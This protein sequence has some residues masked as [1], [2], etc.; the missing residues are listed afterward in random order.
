[1]SFLSDVFSGNF[2]NLG[3]DL[4]PSNI[5]SDTGSSFSNQPGWAQGLELGGAALLG[6]LALPELLPAAGALDLGGGAAASFGAASDAF[7]VAGGLGPGLAGT[8]FDTTGG[9][10]LAGLDASAI[11]SNAVL[12]ATSSLTAGTSDAFGGAG[13]AL[14]MGGG[15]TLD[16]A[17]AAATGIP[18][19]G[20]SAAP[21]AP[22]FAQDLTSNELL[23]G[24]GVGGGSPAGTFAAAPGAAGGASG[25]VLTDT[26]SGIGNFL[27]S[28]AGKGAT[29]VAGLGG[30]GA[31]LYSGYQQSQA[32]KALNQQEQQNIQQAQ[33]AQ[34][35]AMRSVQ[36]L[37]N[38]GTMLTQYLTN[39]TLP[40]Q[41]QSQVDQ[42]V[43]SSK[44][45][46]IQGYASR[47]QS[48]DP[49]QNTALQQDLANIDQQALGLQAQF[50]EVLSSAGQQMIQTANQL[51]ST[52]L[53]ATSLASEIPIAVS[54]LNQSINIQMSQAISS[55]A[56]ALNGGQRNQGGPGTLTLNLNPSTGAI[57]Q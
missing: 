34:S 24:T 29:A 37:L 25:N 51:L 52:G 42:W 27:G 49:K 26:L 45:A 39:N 8:A 40:P 55:F 22:S 12:P 57:Q 56:A 18:T 32:L 9:V 20:V 21:A 3:N 14:D 16:P 30:L 54:K 53:S 10:P 35:A 48:G 23:A 38:N 33:A 41:F 17:A 1:M 46:I 36:P 4:A 5:F 50:E 19:G 15:G 13:T 11:E 2:S 6:G 47:G 28:P 44:A 31:N 7:D 43:K